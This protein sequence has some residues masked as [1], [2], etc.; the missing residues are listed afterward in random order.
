MKLK[1]YAS[2]LLVLGLCFVGSINVSFANE[3]KNIESDDTKALIEE[4]ISAFN[5]IDNQIRENRAEKSQPNKKQFKSVQS[6]QSEEGTYPTQ[7]GAILVTKD[8]KFGELV[9]H[10]GIVYNSTT[11][12]E[13]YTENGVG[14]Y[15]NTWNTSC[16]NAYGL[17]V[18]DSSPQKDQDAANYAYK[19]VGKPYNWNFFNTETTDSFYCSQL[20]YKAYKDTTGIDLN[21]GGGIVTPVN[22]IQ[23]DKTSCIYSMGV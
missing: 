9:G 21:Y 12:V 15:P 13:S 10:A 14:T 8:S 16:K 1:K 5:E 23:S 18:K 7:P 6:E 22:L 17:L 19:Q 11:T 4:Q 20:V 2:S 3:S